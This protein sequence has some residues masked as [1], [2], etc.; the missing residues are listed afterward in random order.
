MAYSKA[1]LKSTGDKASPC[2]KPFLNEALINVYIQKRTTI[3]NITYNT[4]H[5]YLLIS[6]ITHNITQLVSAV[7]NISKFIQL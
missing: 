7:I 6:S 5:M 3:L 1:K 4:S 2:F